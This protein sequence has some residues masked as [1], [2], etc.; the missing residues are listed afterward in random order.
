MIGT[1]TNDIKAHSE[2]Y[3][4]MPTY[5]KFD[6]PPISDKGTYPVHFRMV[7]FPISEN[8]F[9]VFIMIIILLLE[10]HYLL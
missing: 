7:R 9:E 4:F 6:Y 3:K 2:K 8:Q 10:T 1:N 5:Q